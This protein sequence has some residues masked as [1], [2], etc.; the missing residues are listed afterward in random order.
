VLGTGY[1]LPGPAL[2]TQ[3]LLDRCLADLAHAATRHRAAAMARHLGITHRHIVR[4]LEKP[5]EV[6]RAGHSNPELAAQAVRAALAQAGKTVQ[7]ICY[8]IGHTATPATAIPAN[9]AWV[10]DELGYAGPVAEFR[11]ACTGFANALIFA[12]GLAPSQGV[13]VIVGSE[14]GSVFFDTNRMLEDEGQLLN[15]V[16][17]GD[18]AAAIVLRP[19]EGHGAHIVSS[20]FGSSGLGRAPGFALAHGAA[21]FTHDFDSVRTHGAAL[22]EQGLAASGTHAALCKWIIPHQANGRIDA[23]L[24]PV[25]GVDQTRLF[26]VASRIGNT[27]SAAIWTAF[28]MLREAGLDPG[29]HVLVLGAEAT[30]Y[31]YG[32]F[33]YVHA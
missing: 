8:L 33:T 12:Q 23:L 3:A 25:L 16:Q 4:A 27:G 18:S 22:F 11:Q 5:V 6:P 10:A 32:G 29:D 13:V 28:A 31:F 24:A 14:T 17:M 30:K 9:I 20:F 26:N 15:F 21:E 2:D 7:D 1:V 19:F